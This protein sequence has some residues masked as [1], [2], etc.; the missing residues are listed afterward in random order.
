M[1]YNTTFD[2]EVY[3]LDGTTD[4]ME[5]FRA[6]IADAAERLALSPAAMADLNVEAISRLDRA[7]EAYGEA[8]ERFWEAY[9]Y[10]LEAG[11]VSMKWYGYHEDMLKL[12]RAYP[13]FTFELNGEGEDHRPGAVFQYWYRDG[14]SQGGPAKMTW[15]EFQEDGWE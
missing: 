7:I 15:P 4:A 8:G 13:M 2:L 1:G 11:G 6:M 10:G 14:K 12:S 5:K 3:E 9:E